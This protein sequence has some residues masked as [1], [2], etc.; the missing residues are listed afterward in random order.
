MISALNAAPPNH[1]Q[2]ARGR[3]NQPVAE[4]LGGCSSGTVAG[5]ATPQSSGYPRCASSVGLRPRASIAFELKTNRPVALSRTNRLNSAS[6]SICMAP[7]I[8]AA[9]TMSAMDLGRVNSRSSRPTP[10]SPPPRS[11]ETYF[12][13]VLR[14]TLLA[15]DVVE[16]ILD[17]RPPPEITLALM[18]RPF[19]V[20]WTEQRKTLIG[21]LPRSL[22]C[23]DAVA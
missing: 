9:R 12:G 2:D 22:A 3:P 23:L 10:R 15:P 19:A 8:L 11:N 5:L 7:P 6:T 4:G 18:M 16:A 21:C 14:L 13:R 20:T 17:G 1:R